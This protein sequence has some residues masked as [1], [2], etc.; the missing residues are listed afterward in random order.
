M[1]KASKHE[2]PLE[3]RYLRT[4]QEERFNRTGVYASS[5]GEMF[6][7]RLLTSILVL[8]AYAAF[9]TFFHLMKDSSSYIKIP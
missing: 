9:I 4:S 3:K 6:S 1:L 8:L 2:T 7:M 5:F